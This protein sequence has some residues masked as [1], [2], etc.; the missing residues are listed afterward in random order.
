MLDR[1]VGVVEL[2]AHR[3]HV[4]ALA[5]AEQFPQKVVGQHLNVV[6]E[7]Q[8]VLALG[9]RRAEVVDGREVERALV[10]DD[11]AVGKAAGQCL[12][13]GKRCRVS[14]VVLDDDDLKIVVARAFVQARQAA[15]QVVNVVFTGDQYADLRV[16]GQLVPHLKCAGRVGHGHGV[17]R[18][19]ETFELRVDGALPRRDGVGLGLHARSGGAGRGTPDVEH[20]LD[21]LDALCFFCQ[22]QDQI[23]VLRT[24]KLLRLIRARR[25]QQ[26]TAEH[27][28]MRDKVDPAQVVGR[29]VGLEVVAAQLLQIGGE[30]DFITIDKIR[31]GVLYR[32]HNLEQRVR[33]EHVV[34][35]QQR[36]VL[37]VRQRKS[38][39]RVEGNAAVFNRLIHNRAGHSLGQTKLQPLVGVGCVHQHQFPVCVGLPDDA[40]Q[41]LVKQLGGRV[42]Q[43]HDDADLR[44]LQVR[45][46]LG[47]QLPAQRNV[48]A[49][50]PVVVVHRQPD[51]EFHIAPE[52]LDP[53]LPQG[54]DAAPRE[55][56]QVGGV[57]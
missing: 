9:K 19:T 4:G 13:I 6:V 32:L 47:L 38:A 29:K 15:V 16:A 41:H 48:G 54:L 30:N 8:Q 37:A 23:M 50:P 10:V 17:A 24:V 49:V 40:L 22:A 34:V 33:V 28:Q 18:Q 31:S 56:P 20:L 2:R 25:V 12:V 43:R 27:R 42:V 53:L 21:M 36:D 39:G 1:V 57:Q 26:R 7:Q 44:P 5:V 51:A 11:A 52:L 35:V 55:V 46:A 3:T 45:G 14:G